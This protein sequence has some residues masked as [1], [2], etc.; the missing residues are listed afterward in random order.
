MISLICIVCYFFLENSSV[1]PDLVE[2][3]SKFRHYGFPTFFL[4]GLFKYGLL[5]IGIGIIII[6]SFLL[7]Q[8]KLVQNSDTKS[9]KK[10][11]ESANASV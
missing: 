6:L 7:I 2:I 4:T 10:T 8:E 1:I 3:M 5:F 9:N 11:L